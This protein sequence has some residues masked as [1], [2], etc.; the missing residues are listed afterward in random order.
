MERE[1][2]KEEVLPPSAWPQSR[3]NLATAVLRVD[4]HLGQTPAAPAAAAGAAGLAGEAVAATGAGAGAGAGAGEGEGLAGWA[5]GWAGRGAWEGSTE[6][7]RSRL[8]SAFL[9]GEVRE[10]RGEDR[11][12]GGRMERDDEESGRGREREE[13]RRA[14]LLSS[15]SIS[16]W[17]RSVGAGGFWTGEPVAG[18]RG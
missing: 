11:I 6:P 15:A 4:L 1:E 18:R 9:K 13:G 16:A 7:E 3:Q 5:A 8:N 17:M 12:L 2:R 10:G 14:N